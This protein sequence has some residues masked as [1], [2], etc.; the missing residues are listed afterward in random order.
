MEAVGDAPYITDCATGEKED[1]RDDAAPAD[2][3]SSWLSMLLGRRSC[4]FY[5][6]DADEK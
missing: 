5:F 1:W 4:S 6:V 2:Y 3:W